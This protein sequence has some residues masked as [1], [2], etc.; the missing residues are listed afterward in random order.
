MALKPLRDL[1]QINVVEKDNKAGIFYTVD[2]WD[3]ANNQGEVIAVGDDVVGFKA[4]D[5]VLFNPYAMLEAQMSGD[6]KDKVRFIKQD[7][8]LA[9]L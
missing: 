2:K 6:V 4:G 7:D 3:Q 5:K 8:I 9:I 1:I